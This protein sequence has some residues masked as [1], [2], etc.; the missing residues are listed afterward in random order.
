MNKK[1][2]STAAALALIMLL[3]GCSGNT[4]PSLS[5][6]TPD[7]TAAATSESQEDATA[8][9]ES[10]EA[11]EDTTVES[12]EEG[13]SATQN[14]EPVDVN[15]DISEYILSDNDTA[16]EMAEKID[17][18]YKVDV[19]FGDDIRTVFDVDGDNIHA[20]KY[21]NEEG[22]KTALKS[23]D[24][25]LGVFPQGLT[26]QLSQSS[27]GILKI[28][29]T[30]AIGKGDA[31]PEPG[32]YPAFTDDKDTELYL[33]IDI[34]QDGVINVPTVSHELT[35]VIDFRLHDMGLMDENEWNKLNPEGFKY[36]EDYDNYR[37]CEYTDKYSYCSEHYTPRT[38][39]QPD[40]DVYFYYNYS[41]VN[42]YEDRA[43]LM[44]NLVIYRLW[45][46]EVAPGLY[47]FEHVKAKASYLLEK[48]S[49]AFQ[50]NE[51]DVASW[52]KSFE[53]I[54]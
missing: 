52:K 50:L 27:K 35:H 54:S 43:T 14:T 45:N 31:K 40:G 39:S 42:A 38:L 32:Q 1:I 46:Y 12:K 9:S 15:R 41:V 37:N 28:Y 23:V 48:I 6:T 33:T 30:G 51:Q 11:S 47:K 19:I 34:S 49:Q 24:E 7:T 44:E 3:S 10:S 8:A 29:L 16:L 22:I 21:T 36:T 5:E 4:A 13:S 26:E 17:K 25:A 20:E 18:K 53:E 2:Q